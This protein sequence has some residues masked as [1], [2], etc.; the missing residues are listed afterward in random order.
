MA[1]PL[2]TPGSPI[3]VACAMAS[4]T[5]FVGE[6]LP[7]TQQMLQLFQDGGCLTHRPSGAR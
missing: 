1:S 3:R 7:V 2:K 4:A 5:C 6:I